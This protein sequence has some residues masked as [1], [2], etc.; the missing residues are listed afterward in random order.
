MLK[1]L[2]QSNCAKMSEVLIYLCSHYIKKRIEKVNMLSKSMQ[3][4]ITL[5][6]VCFLIGTVKAFDITTMLTNQPRHDQT[7]TRWKTRKMLYKALTF[8]ISCI[9]KSHNVYEKWNFSY[10]H[11]VVFQ[12]IVSLVVFK[13]HVTNF[14]CIQHSNKCFTP[15]KVTCWRVDAGCFV[16]T[17]FTF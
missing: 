14:I 13:L 4:R 11:W 2:F 6:D 5:Y 9:P 7:M 8:Y 10:V 17:A 3:K 1:E 15:R 16:C 12:S